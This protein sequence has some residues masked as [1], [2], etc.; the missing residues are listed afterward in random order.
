EGAVETAIERRER[1]GLNGR[2]RL[3]WATLCALSVCLPF[4]A[5]GAGQTQSAV[6]APAETRI[7][8]TK[9]AGTVVS[10]T[11]GAPLAQ[12]RVSIADTKNRANMRW[13]VTNESGRFEFGQVPAG[14]YSLEGAKRGYLT[15]AYEQHEQ[16][17]TAIVTG[18]EFD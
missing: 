4:G 15:A 6:R 9:I 5:T 18:T 7:A 17:S 11:T 14:K 8:P 3:H 16:F 12:T 13:M 2:V 10:A 1:I